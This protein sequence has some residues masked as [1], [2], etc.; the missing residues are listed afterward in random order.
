MDKYIQHDWEFKLAICVTC[1][2]GLPTPREQVLRHFQ[3]H[4]KET[5]KKHRDELKDHVW[6]MALVEKRELHSPTGIRSAIDHLE[7][8]D[9]WSCRAEG[10]CFMSVSKKYVMDHCRKEHAKEVAATKP[11]FQCRMQTLLGNPNIR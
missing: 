7:V 1:Q 10:C 11:W 5:W 6:S 9:G 4:H 3:A 2:V 8:K